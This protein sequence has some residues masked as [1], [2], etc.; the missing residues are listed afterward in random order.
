MNKIILKHSTVPG[1]IPTS[2]ELSLGEIAINIADGRMFTKTASGSIESLAQS[3]DL[4]SFSVIN[5][6]I[7][8]MSATGPSQAFTVKGGSGVKITAIS[9]SRELIVAL[10][11]A[12]AATLG[13]HAPS[14]F[15]TATH[16]HDDR[17][18]KLQSQGGDYYTQAQVNSQINSAIDNLVGGASS[19]FDT[20]KE[21][22]D[23]LKDKGD[24]VAAINATLATKLDASLYTAADVLAKL[25]TVHGASS[26]LDAALLA[27]QNSAFYRNAGNLN[28]GT[29]PVARLSGIYNIGV[30]GNAATATKLA[31]AF[32][33]SLAGHAFGSVAI[34]G[35][36]NATLNVTVANDSHTHDARY[37][38]KSQADGRY[39]QLA[40]ANTWGD[41][42]TLGTRALTDSSADAAIRIA[43]R[44]TAGQRRVYMELQGALANDVA[45]EDGGAFIKF[46]TSTAAN[47]GPEIGAVRRSGGSGDMIL[48][49]GGSD[50][51]DRL[52]I[53][54]NGDIFVNKLNGIIKNA[55]LFD[56]GHGN[57]LDA[58]TLDGQHLGDIVGAA[59]AD[60]TAHK[61]GGD[62]DGRYVNLDGDRMTGPLGIGQGVEAGFQIAYDPATKSLNFNFVGV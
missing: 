48:R 21:L 51:Q 13:G 9:G 45:N 40:T 56:A 26:G 39:G 62:H 61:N 23:A 50:V 6:D 2:D 10:N 11:N 24:A 43:G 30:S 46:R 17:Y 54:D 14:H 3:V 33:L 22:E 34:D 7:G 12:D 47:F 19:A 16:L 18:L 38:E 59:T 25:K 29:V 53:R 31:S 44:G 4:N 58:D 20:L 55:A 49:T 32:S 42:Q 5:G 35:S 28:A 15:A 37:Y 27:G 60:L 8:S 1:K 36:S 41:V 52:T 57:G